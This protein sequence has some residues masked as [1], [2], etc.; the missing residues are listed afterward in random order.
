MSA[1]NEAGLFLSR[2]YLAKSL[3]IAGIVAEKGSDLG[4]TFV[5]ARRMSE[6]VDALTVTSKTMLLAEE[7]KASSGKR[8]MENPAIWTIK[9]P[10]S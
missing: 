9:A 5:T 7:K 4:E 8:G 1:L 3:N 6:F 10:S 2:K